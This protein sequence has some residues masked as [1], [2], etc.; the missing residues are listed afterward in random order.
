MWRNT[1]VINNV[2]KNTIIKINSQPTPN[3]K[4]KLTNIILNKIKKQKK[5]M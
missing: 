5:N 1:I 3:L 4:N 2:L